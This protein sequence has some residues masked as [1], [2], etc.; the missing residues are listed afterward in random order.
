MVE[1]VKVPKSVA[2]YAE[3]KGK[4]E[5]LPPSQIIRSLMQKG[6]FAEQAERSKRDEN[7]R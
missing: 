1:V 4:Q 7:K 3:E 6:M 2:I 5:F